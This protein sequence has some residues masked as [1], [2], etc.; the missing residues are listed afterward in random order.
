MRCALLSSFNLDLVPKLVSELVAGNGLSTEWYLG[1]FNQYAQL[2]L[3]ER[4]ALYSYNP[5]VIFLSVAGEDLFGG[6]SECSERDAAYR[7]TEA[8]GRICFR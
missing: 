7:R 3:D 4:S 8:T 6:L 2:I 1:G 5:D